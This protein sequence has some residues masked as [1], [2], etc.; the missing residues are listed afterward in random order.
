VRELIV[1][2]AEW[3]SV[4]LALK[5]MLEHAGIHYREIDLTKMENYKEFLYEKTGYWGTPGIMLEGQPLGGFPDL[6]QKLHS[7]K[8]DDLKMNKEQKNV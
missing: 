1:Y 2:S 3:C 6:V 4:C 7:G 5:K 8:L